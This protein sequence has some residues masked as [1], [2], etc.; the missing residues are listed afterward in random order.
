MIRPF[1]RC[2][3]CRCEVAVDAV[4]PR[5]VLGAESG[6]KPCAHLAAAVA[7]LRVCRLTDGDAEEE[8]PERSGEWLFLH[9]SGVRPYERRGSLQLLKE[10]D[11]ALLQAKSDW[12]QVA[13]LLEYR[14]EG[15]YLLLKKLQDGRFQPWQPLNVECRI[16]GGTSDM[17]DDASP[18]T[19]SFPLPGPDGVALRATL[20]GW[21]AFSPE[22]ARCAA[23]VSG[24][25]KPCRDFEFK[26]W[27][28][29]GGPPKQSALSPEQDYQIVI[30]ELGGNTPPPA[31]VGWQVEFWWRTLGY[32]VGFAWVAAGHAEEPERAY[33]RSVLVHDEYRRQGIATRLIEACRERWS[34]LRLSPPTSAAGLE[35]Y[36]KCVTALPL[37]EAAPWEKIEEWLMGGLS[38]TEVIQRARDDHES[39]LR[40][41]AGADEQDDGQDADEQEED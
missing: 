9:G 37:E 32:P 12:S 4:T 16:D 19:G 6:D 22:P 40:Y 10:A 8:V 31:E 30:R 21:A 35:L 1:A 41:S 20:T 15:W 7:S 36:W 25:L 38:R 11:P 13:P 14:D 33:V 17:L 24:L 29:V 18:G 5:L 26:N 28:R 34:D 27:R 2:P 3:Y 39:R 23:E